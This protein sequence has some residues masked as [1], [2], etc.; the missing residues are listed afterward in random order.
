MTR[1]AEIPMGIVSMAKHLRVGQYK[2]PCPIC[3]HT[4]SKNG[5]DKPLSV[6]VDSKG[7]RFFC[8]HCDEEGGWVHE[9][10]TRFSPSSNVPVRITPLRIVPVE[11]PVADIAREYLMERGITESVIEA[12]TIPGTYR[13]NGKPTPAIGFPYRDGGDTVAIKWRS[14]DADKRF[15]QQNKC[16]DFFL[17]DSYKDG[18]DIIICEGEIDALAWM[19]AGLPENVSVMSIP[20]GAPAK[21]RDGKV[22]PKD[23]NKF[24]SLWRAKDRLDTARHIYVN[25]DNDEPGRALAEE[26]SRRVDRKKLWVTSLGDYKDAA[27]ALKGGGTSFLLTALEDSTAVPLMGLHTADDFCD[28]FQDLYNNGLTSGASTGMDSLDGLFTVAPGMVTIVTGIPGH[29][30]SD[31]VDQICMNLGKDRGWKTAYCSFEK[32]VELHMAQLAEKLIGKPFFD[33]ATPRMSPSD[34]DYAVDWLSKHFMFMDYRKGGP[35]DI[36]GIL[37]AASAAVMR[38]GCRIL[39]IDPYNYIEVDRSLRETDVISDILTKLRQWAKVHDCHV[40]FIAHPAKVGGDRLGKKLVVGGHEISGSAA[41][42]AKADFGLTVWRDM[43]GAEPSE[44]HI[45]KVKWSWLG[46]VGHAPLHFDP[47]T[48][49]WRDLETA[50][51]DFCWDIPDDCWDS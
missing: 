11:A 46:R 50:D 5:N 6:S 24:Q 21:V 13:F 19:S 12:H 41:W 43:S 30:K 23:D 37:E 27:D 47:I 33:G 25:A 16:E 28:P 34:R 44:A 35:S 10:Q 29:G 39:V 8:H 18:N 49:R 4:R 2:K 32:P 42:F 7:V 9:N 40:F 26:I 36:D 1:I 45:W 22:D 17:L 38:M 48:T 20:N 15:S 51:D 31:L 3:Q 14:A